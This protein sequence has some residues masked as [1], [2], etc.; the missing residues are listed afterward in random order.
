MKKLDEKTQIRILQAIDELSENPNL[1]ER[2]RGDLKEF[3][4]LK[5]TYQEKL[6]LLAYRNS[7]EGNLELV[8]IGSHQNFY[9]TL[10]K[11]REG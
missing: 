3:F 8:D 9:R 5:F 11:R 4:V 10:R 2:K 7:S 1:G 6:W